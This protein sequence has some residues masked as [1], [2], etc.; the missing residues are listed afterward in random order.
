M[1]N[2]EFLKRLSEVAEWYRPQT[3]PNGCYSVN[4]NAKLRKIE[5]PGTVTEAELAA[6]DEDEV[7]EYY[8]QLMAWRESQPNEL[9]PPEIKKLKIQSKD[10]EDCHRHCP[11]G[12]Q[13]QSKICSTGQ[14]HWR[15]SC[16]TCGLYR[17]PAT[18]QF[19]LT[20]KEVHNYMTGYYRP[21]LGVY[22]SKYQPQNKA[23][24][25][26]R[27]PRGRPKLTKSEITEKIRVEGDWIIRETDD[28]VIRTFMP[29]NQG[30]D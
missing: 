3:G 19:T 15:T 1:N 6:M 21:K 5:H 24:P 11:E 14:P 16:V 30:L 4:K 17:D 26:P 9:V 8:E 2:D 12:R 13:V 28:A 20:N 10:C 25:K 22:A 29:K 23:E 27:G 7:Q 18:G